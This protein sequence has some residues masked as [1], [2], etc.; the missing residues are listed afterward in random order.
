VFSQRLDIKNFGAIGGG[1][2][3]WL[4]GGTM[5]S[6][7]DEPMTGVWG[8]IPRRGL[9]AEPLHGQGVKRR[10]ILVN[11][12]PTEPANLAPFQKCPL[13][14]RYMQ[15]CSPKKEVGTPKTRLRQ[16]F[17]KKLGL[18]TRQKNGHSGSLVL[19]CDTA[20]RV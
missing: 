2:G 10:N 17:K 11:G 3:Q 18:H 7:E 4:G 16:R 8:Q 12:C 13:E 1:R 20:T 9:R 5:A 15:G 6:A 19:S 14:L